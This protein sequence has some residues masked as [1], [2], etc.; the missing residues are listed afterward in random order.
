MVGGFICVSEWRLMKKWGR[1][2][3]KGE[4]HLTLSTQ[5]SATL[6]TACCTFPL[7]LPP[8][9]S[10]LLTAHAFL[11]SIISFSKSPKPF[12][13]HNFTNLF[14]GCVGY[15][16]YSQCRGFW[17]I[18]GRNETVLIHAYGMMRS[19]T[20]RTVWW[21]WGGRRGVVGRCE[22]TKKVRMKSGP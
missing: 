5:L 15:T 9:Q 18:L 13:S 16:L 8:H 19:L 14:Q 17:Y 20:W 1:G 21:V 22:R 10:H 3:M 12:S 2:G 11:S 6:L 7:S 4:V